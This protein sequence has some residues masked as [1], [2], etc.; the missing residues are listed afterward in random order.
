MLCRM[1]QKIKTDGYGQHTDC[2]I[3]LIKE[4]K[5]EKIQMLNKNIKQLEELSINVKQAIIEIKLLLE[6]VDED[7]EKLKTEIQNSFTKLRNELNKKEDEIFLQI[8]N[9]YEEL[10]F[11]KQF[12]L[13]IKKLPDKIDKSLKKEKC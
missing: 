1:Y 11:E 4:I 6:K 9:K 2:E 3:C 8:D 12:I 13:D 10:F 7:K 5:D